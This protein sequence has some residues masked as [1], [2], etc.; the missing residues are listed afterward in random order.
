MGRT[1][2]N[3]CSETIQ[4][5][6]ELQDKNDWL[7]TM[8]ISGNTNTQQVIAY[9]LIDQEIIDGRKEWEYQT[10]AIT[11]GEDEITSADELFTPYFIDPKSDDDVDIL[12]IKDYVNPY[13]FNDRNDWFENGY[14]KLSAEELQS[15][16]DALFYKSESSGGAIE[17]MQNFWLR[18]MDSNGGRPILLYRK[19]YL[20]SFES[21]NKEMIR[22]YSVMVPRG[23]PR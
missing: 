16:Y 6:E 8:I 20:P 9:L 11:W 22:W 12:G 3:T 23:H 14:C 7:N 2:W 13:V 18:L 21:I 1:I 17:S 15:I 10:I 19:S 5:I 4:T